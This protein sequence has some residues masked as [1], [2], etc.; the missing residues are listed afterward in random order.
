LT[1]G[2]GVNCD[3]L[4]I[5]IG[6]GIGAGGMSAAI[7]ARLAGLDVLVIEKQPVFGGSTARSGGNLWIPCS[8]V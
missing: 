8:D 7:T 1:R 2:H 5:G 3:V 6:I 4:V